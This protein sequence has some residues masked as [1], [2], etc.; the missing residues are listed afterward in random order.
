MQVEKELGRVVKKETKKFVDWKLVMM[1]FSL[2]PLKLPF[3][4][5]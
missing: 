5:T 1:T 3:K 2:I 4:F